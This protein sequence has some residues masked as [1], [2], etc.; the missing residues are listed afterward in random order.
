MDYSPP[1]TGKPEGVR[2]G[3]RL[4]NYHSCTNL[5]FNDYLYKKSLPAKVNRRNHTDKNNRRTAPN[6]R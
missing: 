6:N 5:F 2:L 3:E 1:I 4:I